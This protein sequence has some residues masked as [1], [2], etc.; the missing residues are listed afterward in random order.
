MPSSRKREPPLQRHRRQPAHAA[1]E[2]R[3]LTPASSGH[4]PGRAGVLRLQ[5]T[6]GNAG[7]ARLL[8]GPQAATHAL[9]ALIQRQGPAVEE[10]PAGTEGALL[11]AAAIADARRYYTAQPWLYTPAI[12]AQLRGALGLDPDGGVDDALVLAVAEFQATEGAGDPALKIDG[13]AGPRT[14]PRIFREGLNV[15]ETGREF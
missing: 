14:L 7:V 5:Q 9:A 2:G 8:A 4:L 12:I 1:A 13:K 11:D 3:G 15:E 10:A 6:L